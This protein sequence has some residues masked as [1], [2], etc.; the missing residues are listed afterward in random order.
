MDA[1]TREFVRQRAGNRCEYCRLSQEAAPFFSFHIEHI[2]ARQ[3]GGSDDRN[4]LALACPD[5][6]AKK[7]PNVATVAAETGDLVELFNPRKHVWDEHFSLVGAEI[8]GTSAI[9]RA[10]TLLL[11]LNGDERVAVRA[12]LQEEGLL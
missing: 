10:T 4:N 12:Q 8:I 2:R 3:H 11:E 1:A 7:G 9:G 6:N 5:C